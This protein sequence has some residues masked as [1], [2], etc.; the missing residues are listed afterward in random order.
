[1]SRRLLKIP[2]PVESKLMVDVTT[3]VMLGGDY[4]IHRGDEVEIAYTQWFVVSYWATLQES[5]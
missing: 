3:I 4:Y 5:N 1:M 2:R